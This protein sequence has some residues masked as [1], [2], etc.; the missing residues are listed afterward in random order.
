MGHAS[1]RGNVV[2]LYINGLYWG[3]YNPSERPDDSFAAEHFG[4]DKSEYD[5][6]N[7]DGLHSGTLDT[8]NTMLSLAQAVNLSFR[9]RRQERRLPAAAGKFRQ[10]CR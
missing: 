8:Y 5:V 9:R 6:V 3:L 2:H 4:G 10:R 1:S 7:H